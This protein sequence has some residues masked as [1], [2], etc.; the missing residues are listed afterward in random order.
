MSILANIK[1]IEENAEERLSIC[2]RCDFYWAE[3]GTCKACGCFMQAKA[4]GPSF[5]CPKG[6]WGTYKL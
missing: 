4:R 5:S 6:Y 1:I 3:V 2:R